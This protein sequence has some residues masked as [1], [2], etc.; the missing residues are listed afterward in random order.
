MQVAVLGPLEVRT[1]ELAPVLV[2]GARERLL[3]ALLVAR[4]P[5]AVGID[6]PGGDALGRAASEDAPQ[7]VRALVLGLRAALEPGLPVNVSGR[8][9]L[10]RG[11]GYALALPRGD[12]DAERFVVLTERAQSRLAAGDAAEAER[13]A[14][15]A[16][17]LWRGTPYAD[18]PD[19]AS[20]EDERRRLDA[21][22]AV[23][24]TTV[25]EARSRPAPHARARATRHLRRPVAGPGP[26]PGP[27][28]GGPGRRPDAAPG[29]APYAG[30]GAAPGAS[31]PDIEPV[32]APAPDSLAPE[33]MS[34]VQPR[35]L[36]L[37]AL[38]LVGV[39]VATVLA[40]RSQRPDP[41]PSVTP[42]R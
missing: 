36:L 24:E 30:S 12:I 15:A 13:L 26:E 41:R 17:G 1:D 5:K 37:P 38:L 34:S 31:R 33:P 22:R 3:L 14:T 42:R 16:L 40:V 10:R 25:V 23:A 2:P 7:S 11:P 6:G 21:V 35:R 19:V 20:F 28:P 27:A 9:V 4:S 18:W 32:R 29:A 8:Y 39:L